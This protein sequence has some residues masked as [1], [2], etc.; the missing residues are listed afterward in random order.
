M[1]ETE[2]TRQLTT[3]EELAKHLA[4]KEDIAATHAKIEQVRADL[5]EHL[6][7]SERGQRM[8]I[9]GLY[10]LIILSHFWPK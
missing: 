6:L 5:L 2:I 10:A 7:T 8:W 9:W 1:N 3:F 4:T